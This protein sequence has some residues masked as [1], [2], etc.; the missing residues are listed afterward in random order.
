[1]LALD[2][3]LESDYDNKYCFW[4]KDGITENL[5]KNSARILGSRAF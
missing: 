1:M 5:I 2:L 4:V 3:D